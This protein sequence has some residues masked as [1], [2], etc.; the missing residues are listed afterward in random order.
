MKTRILLMAAAFGLLLGA[1]PVTA[2]EP[3]RVGYVNVG[4]L[5]EQAPQAQAAFEELQRDFEPIQ[6]EMMEERERLQRL[7]QEL[8][9]DEEILGDAERRELEAEIRDLQRELQ[10]KESDYSEDL[11]AR[12]N[13]ALNVLQ[14]L[15]MS[16]V[17]AYSR[18]NGLDLVVGEGVFYA[19][20]RVDITEGVLE[21]LRERHEENTD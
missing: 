12:R 13:E 18:E 8:S 20:N 10:R 4:E 19:A 21:R 6:R 11:N 15:I 3:V 9:R 14:R 7:Q 5:M 16:E 2:D 17:Q 1:S